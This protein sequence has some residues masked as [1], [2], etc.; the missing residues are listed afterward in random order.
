MP[1]STIGIGKIGSISLK[2]PRFRKK[3]L[4]KFVFRK[5]PSKGFGLSR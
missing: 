2:D 3:L 4:K 1:L 5:L